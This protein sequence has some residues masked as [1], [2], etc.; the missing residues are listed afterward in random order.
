MEN[1]KD[2]ENGY[3]MRVAYP[4]KWRVKIGQ[5]ECDC[6]EVIERFTPW[7]GFDWFHSDECALMQR[8]KKSPQLQ[9]LPAFADL[10]HLAGGE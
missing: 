3:K 10:P 1:D 9:N 8:V 4:F 7:Y 5:T 2:Y 6:T